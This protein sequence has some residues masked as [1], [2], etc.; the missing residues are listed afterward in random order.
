MTRVLRLTLGVAV[1]M[2]VGVVSA[3]GIAHWEAARQFVAGD[4]EAFDGIARAPVSEPFVLDNVSLWDGRSGAVQRGRSVLV[5]DG[6]IAGIL[7][8]GVPL[9]TGVRFIDAAE[10]TLIPVSSTRTCT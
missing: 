7:D 6:R 8:V 1:L 9:P 2:V 10:K 3:A 4:A 5:N